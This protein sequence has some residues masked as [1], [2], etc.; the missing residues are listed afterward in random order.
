[1]DR[2]IILNCPLPFPL[3]IIHHTPAVYPESSPEASFHVLNKQHPESDW[4]EFSSG[5][6]TFSQL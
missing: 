1:M 6:S 2:K 5:A 4:E 3:D